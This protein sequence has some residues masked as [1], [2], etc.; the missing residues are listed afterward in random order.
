MPRKA[1]TT[2]AGDLAARFAAIASFGAAVI[3][4]AVVPTHW[5]GWPPSGFFFAI[6]ALFQLIWAY[7]VLTRTTA[8]LLISGMLINL[9]AVAL[10][11][12]SRTGGVPFG[13]HAGQAE[14][15]QAADL[16]A[17]LLE[18]YVVM[19]AGWVWSRGR[20]RE[21]VPTVAAAAVLV[22]A[23]A[24]VALASTVGVVSGLQHGHHG[25]PEPAAAVAEAEGTP[26]APA[27][28]QS[29][30]PAAEPMHSHTHGTHHHD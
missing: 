9:G 29:P 11:V 24:V 7:L 22:G 4:F 20:R 5:Q 10:W 23:G 17:V 8:P 13:P 1:T 26:A 25:H 16:C 14:V 3:H 18:I 27:P 19:G 6:L 28:V 21:A 30:P 2:T 12:V 15:A